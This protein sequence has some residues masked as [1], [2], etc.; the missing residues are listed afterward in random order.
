MDN[1]IAVE[2]QSNGARQI[3]ILMAD[4][5]ESLQPLYHQA[6]RRPHLRPARRER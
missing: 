2:R 1:T 5:D 3:R 4:P 6:N